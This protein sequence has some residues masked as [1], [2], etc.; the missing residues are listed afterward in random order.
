MQITVP[1]FINKKLNLDHTE[2][3]LSINKNPFK[4]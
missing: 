4:G 3:Y 1:Q 2:S